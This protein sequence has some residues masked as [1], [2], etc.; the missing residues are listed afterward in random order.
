[1]ADRSWAITPELEGLI[2]K[3]EAHGGASDWTL[4]SETRTRAFLAEKERLQATATGP[5]GARFLCISSVVLCFYSYCNVLCSS[6][7]F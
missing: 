1:M 6:T 7:V 3:A 5:A 2:A 4:S